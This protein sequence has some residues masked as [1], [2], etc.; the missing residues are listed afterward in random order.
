M[1][2]ASSGQP[3]EVAGQHE[4]ENGGNDDEDDDDDDEENHLLLKGQ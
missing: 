2:A 4:G 1:A 3:G